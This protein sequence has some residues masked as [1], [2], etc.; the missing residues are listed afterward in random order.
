MASG[1]GPVGDPVTPADGDTADDDASD[2]APAASR[3]ADDDADDA[4]DGRANKEVPELDR[5]GDGV[6]RT[7]D[8]RGRTVAGVG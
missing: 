5:G 4:E 1:D 2:P 7:S 3:N 6:Q 8:G